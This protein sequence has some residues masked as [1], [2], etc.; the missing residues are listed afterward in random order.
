MVVYTKLSTDAR[1]IR[2]I[3]AA[4]ENGINVDIFTLND[5]E[6]IVISGLNIVSTKFG[7]YKGNSRLK[8][9]LSYVQFFMFCFFSLSINMVRK[10][11]RIVQTH[12]MPDFLVFASLI[13]KLLGAKIILDIH[14]LVPELFAEKYHLSIHHPLI[15]TLFYEERFSANFA[16]VVISTNRLHSQ[17]FR[18]NKIKHEEFPEILNSADEGTFTPF[19]D[20]DFSIRPLIIIFPTTIA[21]RLGLDLLLDVMEILKKEGKNI[22][23]RILGDGEYRDELKNA[24]AER[25]LG[26][27]IYLSNG[28]VSFDVLGVELERAHIGI[29]PWPS[30]YSTNFQMPSK[31]HEYFIKGLC[32]V[33]AELKILKEYFSDSVCFA[34]AGDANDFANKISS[35]LEDPKLMEKFAANGHSFYQ[36]HPWTLYKNKY[37]VILN[38]LTS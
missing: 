32:V 5:S 9:I 28:F 33:G 24:I 30:H 1:V 23:L 34:K 10:R 35:L 38:D 36:Q 20:H 26:D 3:K 2:Q 29:I 25:N 16:D 7:Q 19:T 14:D 11:Y 31:I 13:P 37:I 4:I 6:K 8:Y 12:N 17:R 15:K 27:H 18:L 22:M 21:K